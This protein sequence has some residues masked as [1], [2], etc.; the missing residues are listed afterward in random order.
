MTEMTRPILPARPLALPNLL[1]Y[2][3][4]AAVPVV[5][6]CMYWAGIADGGLWPRWGALAGFLSPAPPRTLRR[7]R[8]ARRGRP[9]PLGRLPDRAAPNPPAP[10]RGALL[11]PRAPSR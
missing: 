11:A 5:V 6:G 8:A 9:S 1:T 7:Y 4:I 3:R 10:P 2:G